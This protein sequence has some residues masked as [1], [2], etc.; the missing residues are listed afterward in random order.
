MQQQE[1]ALS[2]PLGPL[3]LIEHLPG[4]TA[5]ASDRLRWVGLQAHRYRE[6]PPNVRRRC[7]P[8]S[9]A[10]GVDRGGADLWLRDAGAGLARRLWGSTARVP[11]AYGLSL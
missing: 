8:P 10:R 2:H 1:P 5:A 11:G 3:E 9:S 6:Q 7:G 4:E